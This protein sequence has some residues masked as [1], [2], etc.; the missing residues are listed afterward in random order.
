MRSCYFKKT[1]D[2][3]TL[4]RSSKTDTIGRKVF[5]NASSPV[6]AFSRKSFVSI[7]LGCFQT[8]WTHCIVF[9]NKEEASVP[10]FRVLKK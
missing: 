1:S 5:E 7:L 4:S 8:F 9:F 10:T 6:F 3:I 2:D